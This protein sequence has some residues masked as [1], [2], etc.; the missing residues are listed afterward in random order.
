MP[1]IN[2]PSINRRTMHLRVITLFVEKDTVASFIK[3]SEI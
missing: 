2:S 3:L 1:K